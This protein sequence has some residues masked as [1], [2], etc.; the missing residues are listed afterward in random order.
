MIDE[1]RMSMFDGVSSDLPLRNVNLGQGGDG[2]MI[3]TRTIWFAI[4]HP[5]G[6]V[7]I[8]GGNAP[9]VA[10]DAAKHWG[11]ITEMSTPIMSPEQAA[12]PALTAAGVAPADGR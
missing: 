7:V 6:H 12:G 1:V 5:R 2:E 4:T 10:V 9:E 11:A 3:A 8:D